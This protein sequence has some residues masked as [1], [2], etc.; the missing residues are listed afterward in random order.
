MSTTMEAREAGGPMKVL[1]AVD[2]SDG[3]RHALAWVLDHLVEQQQQLVLVHAHEPLH[4]FMYP[5]GPGSA[6]YG[7]ASMMESVR[8]AQAEN[9]RNILDRAKRI[10]HHRGVTAEAVAVEGEPREALCRAAADMGADLLLVGSRGLGAIKRASLPCRRFFYV[11]SPFSGAVLQWERAFQ[12]LFSRNPSVSKRNCQRFLLQRAGLPAPAAA[13]RPLAL[14]TPEPVPGP[15]GTVAS[16]P[17]RACLLPC[18]RRRRPP[19][20][21]SPPTPTAA[22]PPCLASRPPLCRPA[23][24]PRPELVLCPNGAPRS[25]RL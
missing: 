18:P 23:T 20:R 17:S 6:V 12:L 19:P 15:A 4:H 24:S 21:P 5:V 14:V 22:P 3:S 9:A 8:A 16:R 2:D 7:A 1:V 13:A 11:F 10:C 25:G